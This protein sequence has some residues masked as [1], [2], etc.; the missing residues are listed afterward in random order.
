MNECYCNKSK[1]W[2]GLGIG[3]ALGAVCCHLAHTEKAQEL[4]LKMN[5]AIQHATDKAQAMWQSAKQQVTPPDE[6][7]VKE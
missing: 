3:T 4:K 1:F 7:M 5:D 2:I 6:I